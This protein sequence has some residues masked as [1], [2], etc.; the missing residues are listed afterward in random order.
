MPPSLRRGSRCVHLSSS[1]SAPAIRLVTDP[2]RPRSPHKSASCGKEISSLQAIVRFRYGP[3][4]CSPS[5]L[6]RPKAIL[7]LAYDGFLLPS[8]LIQGRPG[9]SGT[10]YGVKLRIAPEGLPPASS[11]ARFAARQPFLPAGLSAATLTPVC[12][13]H[14]ISGCRLRSRQ[15]AESVWE[16]DGLRSLCPT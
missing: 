13:A 7:H 15:A 8:S 4:V 10:C 12:L 5:W 14:T 6:T 3:P 16:S 2:W 11:T 9:T 1:A